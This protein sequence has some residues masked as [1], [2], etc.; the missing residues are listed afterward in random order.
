M[1]DRAWIFL[2]NPFHTATEKSYEQMRKI[3]VYTLGQLQARMAGSAFFTELY[4]LLLPVSTAYIAAFDAWKGQGGMQQGDTLSLKQ[5]LEQLSKNVGKWMDKIDDIHEQDTP[6][7]K[8]LFPHMRVPFQS[9]KQENR[10]SA[11]QAL[12]TNIGDED[13]LQEVKG[14][15]EIFYDSL[16]ATRNTQK[17]SIGETDEK[18]QALEAQRILLGQTLYKILG[19][20]MTEYATDPLQIEPIF[21]LSLIRQQEQTVFTDNILEPNKTQFIVRRHFKEG[22]FVKLMNTGNTELKFYL[23]KKKDDAPG[24]VSAT[25]SPGVETTVLASALG[26]I[27]EQR[28]LMVR[29]MSEEL[30]GAYE[31]ELVEEENN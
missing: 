26:N 1:S 16:T 6:R 24:N 20:L 15:I 18:V 12:I 13:E 28:N 10:I 4:N 3:V 5:K 2:L 29:N 30:D 31:V 21:D 23:A 7:F 9:G 25:L 14:E 8:Q 27:A 17:Q 11:V 22:Q 19:R